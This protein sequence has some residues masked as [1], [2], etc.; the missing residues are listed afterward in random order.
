MRQNI[1]QLIPTMHS[2]AEHQIVPVAL[3]IYGLFIPDFVHLGHRK[4]FFTVIVHKIKHP[5]K[6]TYVA[7]KNDNLK[8]HIDNLFKKSGAYF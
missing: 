3:L 6:N 2:Y 4:A 8:F 7:Y 5:F 1:D